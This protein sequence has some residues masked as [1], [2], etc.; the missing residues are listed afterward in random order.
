MIKR[1]T[2]PK[3]IS[4]ETDSNEALFEKF[5]E[6]FERRYP[7][8]SSAALSR[9]TISDWISVKESMRLLCVGR[10]RLQQL[11]NDGAIRFFQDKKKLRFSKK[12]IEKYL[13]D[14]SS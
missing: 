4:T 14:H 12:S 8:R 1:A 9:D 7:E 11:K 10:T 13:N 2:T 6:F 3:K 5:V